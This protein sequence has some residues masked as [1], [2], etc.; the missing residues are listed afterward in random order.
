MLFHNSEKE[1][2]AHLESTLKRRGTDI[3]AL[4]EKIYCENPHKGFA[5]ETSTTEMQNSF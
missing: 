1:R 3:T 5:V 2:A 4:H